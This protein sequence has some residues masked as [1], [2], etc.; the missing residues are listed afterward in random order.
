MN[1]SKILANLLIKVSRHLLVLHGFTRYDLEFLRSLEGPSLN[2]MR[3]CKTSKGMATILLKSFSTQLF[4]SLLQ[5]NKAWTWQ[6]IWVV[7]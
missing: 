4:P 1:Y 3:G 7:H 2:G 5:R 6:G